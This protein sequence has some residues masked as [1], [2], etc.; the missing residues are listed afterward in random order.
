MTG[1]ARSCWR[2][3][4]GLRSGE[5]RPG[6]EIGEVKTDHLGRGGQGL[7]PPHPAPAREIDP[8]FRVGLERV[9][10]G[11]G[12]RVVASGVDQTIKVS[13]TSDMG[14]QGDGVAFLSIVLIDASIIKFIR[15]R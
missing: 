15:G 4:G 13:G 14:G 7:H 1:D 11:R 2:T 9:V 3:G 5:A 6:G 12:A 8:V 10:G